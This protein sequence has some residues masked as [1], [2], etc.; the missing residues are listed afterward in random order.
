M[1]KAANKSIE[2][3]NFMSVL[4]DSTAGTKK[5][6]KEYIEFASSHGMSVRCVWLTTPIDVAMERNTQ[7]AQRGGANVPH[8]AF[9]T[10]R[11]RFEEPTEDEGFKLW[12]L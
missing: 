10:Y 7:R 4:F 2:E 1:K 9:Y 11:K 6:R 3:E 12:V 8:V 5:V